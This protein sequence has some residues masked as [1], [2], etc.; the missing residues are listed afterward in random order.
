MVLLISVEVFLVVFRFAHRYHDVY[1]LVLFRFIALGVRREWMD[2]EGNARKKKTF[3]TLG[4]DH[5]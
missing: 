4:R 5:F 1:V 2:Y 3:G